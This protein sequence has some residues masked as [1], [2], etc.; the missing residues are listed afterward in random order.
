[1]GTGQ[2]DD[3]RGSAVGGRTGFQID[4]DQVTQL[5]AGV[6]LDQC[7]FHTLADANFNG[8]GC[9]LLDDC[10]GTT[11]PAFCTESTLWNIKKIF[12]FVTGSVQVVDAVNTTVG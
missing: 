7:V 9:V 3:R 12:G 2:V 10:C 6:N 5:F 11:S 8:Y 1:M 4:L